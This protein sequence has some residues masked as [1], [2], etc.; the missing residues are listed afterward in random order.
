MATLLARL[1][2]DHREK[3]LRDELVTLL[4]LRGGQSLP[5][6]AGG[7]GQLILLRV[8]TE[9]TLVHH[10]LLSVAMHKNAQGTPR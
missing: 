4:A 3:K 10:F 5:Q 1:A 9:Q 2:V 8:E 7:H 6:T